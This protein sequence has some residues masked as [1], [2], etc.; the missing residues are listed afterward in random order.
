MKRWRLLLALPLA[1]MLAGWDTRVIK[2]DIWRSTYF[3]GQSASVPE[4]ST[5][6]SMAL[7]ELGVGA[8]FGQNGSASVTVVDLNASYFREDL[9]RKTPL[10]G[11]D[12]ETSVEERLLPPPARFAGLPDYSYGPADW[13]NKNRTCPIG[14]ADDG[15][16]H[17]FL[18]WLG[19]LN[20]VHFGSQATRMYARYHQ[21]ALQR[22]GRARRLRE[23]MSP[24]ERV[25]YRMALRESE[26][27]ALIYE[28][29]AQHFLQDRWAIGHMWERW[30]GPDRTQVA[31]P[32]VWSSVAIGGVAGLIHGA[33]SV[34]SENVSKTSSYTADAMSSPLPGEKAARPM[35]F[36][37][38]SDP[39]GKPV[40]AVGDERLA[41][42]GRGAFGKGYGEGRDQPLDVA[43]QRAEMLTCSKAGW[44][45]VIRALGPGA[46][47]GYG[48]YGAKLAAGAPDFAVL[49][50][51]T[52]WD[53]WATN[54]SMYVGFLGEGKFGP[55]ALAGVAIA[56]PA[57]RVDGKTYNNVDLISLGW[58]MW[59]RQ[60]VDPDGTDLAQGGIG[61]LWD[62]P[63]GDKAGLPVYAEPIEP[64]A[65]P[66][67]SPGG[68]DRQTVFGA[69]S[70][71]HSDHWCG[72]EG[73]EVL[74]LLRRS[75]D[76][77]KQQSCQFLAE[78]AWEGTDPGYDGKM[79]RSR[80]AEGQP[81]RSLCQIR[82][83]R[84]T[85]SGGDPGDPAHIDQGYVSR[86]EADDKAPAFGSKAAANWCARVPVI[87]LSRDPALADQNIIQILPPDAGR[88]ELHG[89]NFGAKEGVVLFFEG[90]GNK[91]G[92][93]RIVDWSDNRIQ[94]NFKRGELQ[95]GLDYLIEIRTDD[96]KRS[97]GLFIL[98]IRPGEEDIAAAPPVASD[99]DG[100]P[101]PVPTFH[102]GDALTR[103]L[104][105]GGATA[106]QKAVADAI[107]K[108]RAQ[109]GATQPPI[110]QFLMKERACILGRKGGGEAVFNRILRDGQQAARTEAAEHIKALRQKG[111]TGN[112]WLRSC[113]K[114]DGRQ[115]EFQALGGAP[116]EDAGAF[117]TDYAAEIDGVVQ[118][119]RFAEVMMEAWAIALERP[120]PLLIPDP[121]LI[122]G[123]YDFR[124]TS[125]EEV[126]RRYFRPS[127]VKGRNAPGAFQLKIQA[128]TEVKL[129]SDS[130]LMLYQATAG[131]IVSRRDFET[132][133]TVQLPRE[134]K[135]PVDAVCSYSPWLLH[136]VAPP[137]FVMM[138]A[139]A[140]DYRAASGRTYQRIGWPARSM[141]QSAQPAAPP[142]P[143]R[144]AG[145]L[146]PMP[147]RPTAPLP[148]PPFS[149]PTLAP[150]PN[151][152]RLSPGRRRNFGGR[153]ARPRHRFWTRSG[154]QA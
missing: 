106:D 74:A 154:R 18:G 128:L 57:V 16:C 117:W 19:G 120:G 6:A 45:E 32:S 78:M 114:S 85:L 129:W 60:W 72:E 50:R 53:M 11:D 127:P 66:K 56:V 88:V 5:L 99:C 150:P 119:G 94:I 111:F 61:S 81:M 65:L 144:P 17:A 139:G 67:E 22:A 122:K 70:L 69:M 30:D 10:E 27:Q 83:V 23:Q 118:Y 13:L 101:P 36:R 52:C 1:L 93:G 145:R 58:T 133:L 12:H 82:Q 3:G 2:K 54:R 47:G 40:P 102:A 41:D 29:Y 46:N 79:K 97:V 148:P 90:D 20:S 109:H 34:L 103:A 140:G 33:E 26:Q 64:S 147:D 91:G 80:M 59:R 152:P 76:P 115:V 55:R 146:P 86:T 130:T 62:A 108:V 84:R 135:D 25:Q 68:V 35:T 136:D 125:P 96:G 100:P 110:R 73:L 124:I 104:G 75:D 63:T 89:Q 116:F 44:A 87:R 151:L 107:R 42:M 142:Q 15:K 95:Q 143:D 77:A 39:D 141:I 9:L 71:A 121:A 134:A 4:H 38:I 48:D 105:P 8:L 149:Q 21:L 137:Q 37:H 31:S 43:R 138:P 14:G 113:A 123:G 92:L 28:G 51:E 153:V 112:T 131:G 7:E 24:A 132:W 49:D 126:V 98:R